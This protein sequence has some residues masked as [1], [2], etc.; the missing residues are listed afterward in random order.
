MP[1]DDRPTLA[2]PDD[3]P[4]LWLEEVEGERALD[5][6]DAAEPV[7]AGKIRRPRHS[8]PIATCLRR[9]MIGRITFPMSRGSGGLLYNLW[10]DAK[11]PR[12]LW[13]RTTLEE[14]RKPDP[15]WEKLLDID[16]LAA[17]EDQDW[18]LSWTADAAAGTLTRDPEPFPRRRRRGD[19][20]GIR[21]SDTK[22]F[23]ADGFTLPEAKSGVEW[24][25]ADTL[26]LSSAYGEGMATTSGYAR[27]VRLWRRGEPVEQRAGACSKRRLIGW[28]RI[29]ASTTPRQRRG[30][31]S[32]SGWISSITMSGSATRPAR[33]QNS[34][35][36]PTSG[37]KRMRTGWR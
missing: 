10:K 13:R 16:R 28:P 3:D 9:S 20:A 30:C 33:R 21:S 36:R 17:E 35:C 25:D 23:V 19:A 32:S 37:W 11:N 4:Y 26:L 1:I 29:A 12:G 6:V 5:F 2:A 34:T 22:A 27:T 24:F 15:Q 8:R 7:D 31:G 18:L 14:F